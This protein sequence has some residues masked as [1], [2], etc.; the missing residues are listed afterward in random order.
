MVKLVGILLLSPFL[1]VSC[2]RICSVQVVESTLI[3]NGLGADQT[4]ELC[5]VPYEQMTGS[6]NDDISTRTQVT[7]YEILQDQDGTFTIDSYFVNVNKTG[8]SKCDNNANATFSSQV[9]LTTKSISQVK[10]CR[11]DVDPVKVQLISLSGTCPAGTTAQ[12]Q[13]V[14]NC[15]DGDLVN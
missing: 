13:P 3:T 10:L 14:I 7:N 15:N 5:K 1:L 2:G 9:F 4:L 6:I 8:Q 11:D 12:V